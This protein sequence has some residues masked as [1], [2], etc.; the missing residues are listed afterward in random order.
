MSSYCEIS[1]WFSKQADCF[2]YADD[3]PTT[4]R[5]LVL[6]RDQPSFPVTGV[7]QYACIV[8]HDTE[9]FVSK[10]KAMGDAHLY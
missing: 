7:K 6:A 2:K 8:S 3:Q 9:T 1:K 4:T 5:T 10:I